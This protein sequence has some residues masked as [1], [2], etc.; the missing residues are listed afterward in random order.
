MLWLVLTT[1]PAVIV[2]KPSMGGKAGQKHPNP[3]PGVCQQLTIKIT[4]RVIN[5][6]RGFIREALF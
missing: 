5:T 3:V 1:C 6:Y 4:M 2:R